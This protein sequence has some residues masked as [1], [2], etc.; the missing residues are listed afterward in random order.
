MKDCVMKGNADTP[1][2]QSCRRYQGKPTAP[3]RQ[4]P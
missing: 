2:R 1:M 4:R 3:R